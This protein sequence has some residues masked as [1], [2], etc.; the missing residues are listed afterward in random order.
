[1]KEEIISFLPPRIYLE[2]RWFHNKLFQKSYFEDIQNRR[3]IISTDS[4]SYKPF[5]DTRSIFIHIPKC[6]GVSINKALF[7]NLAGGHTTLE[8]YLDIFEPSCIL[9]YFKFTIVRNPWDR[10]VSAFNFLKN[11]GFTEN[12][13]AWFNKELKY[14]KSFDEFVRIWLN[15][16]NIWKYHHFR[17]QFHYIYDKREKISIDFLGFFENIEEDFSYIVKRLG[18]DCTLPKLNE[19]QH[20]DYKEHYTQK[21]IEIVAT[22]YSEDINL[23]GYSFDNSSIQKQLND[24]LNRKNYLLRSLGPNPYCG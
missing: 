14:F 22:V 2:A 17:P 6:A 1:M 8:E 15:K 4:Y 11:G 5:D 10:V 7:G 9:S 12:D 18:V 19:S 3:S 24:R 13:R 23:L 20:I 16:E 21:T